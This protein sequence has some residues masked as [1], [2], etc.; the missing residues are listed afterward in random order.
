MM[1]SGI[2]GTL[3]IGVTSNLVQRVWQ[4]REGV[5]D[6]FT[7][8]FGVKRLVWYEMHETMQAAIAR[9]KSLK[10]WNRAWKVRL[11]EERNLAWRDLWEEIC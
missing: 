1:A 10:K 9:E 2:Q 7:E 6:G 3:Y 8:R 4:H 11:I 5:A